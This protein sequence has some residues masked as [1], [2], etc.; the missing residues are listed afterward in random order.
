MGLSSLQAVQTWN[1]NPISNNSYSQKPFK[2]SFRPVATIT[3]A[4]ANHASD[5][6]DTNADKHDA[7]AARLTTVVEGPTKSAS[8]TKEQS[9]HKRERKD[10]TK[11]KGKDHR[12]RTYNHKYKNKVSSFDWA[13]VQ[14][15]QKVEGA[16]GFDKCFW[17]SVSDPE[18]VG[19]LMASAKYH[20]DRMTKAYD[21]SV[22]VLNKKCNAK[23]LYLEKPLLVEVKSDFVQQL[24]S[25]KQNRHLEYVDNIA[26]RPEGKKSRVDH[27]VFK[28]ND[29][30]LVIQKV[31]VAPKPSLAFGYIA[32]KWDLL[33]VKD[34]PKFRSLLT[35]KGIDPKSLEPKL[36][37]ERRKIECVM[38]NSSTYWYDLQGLID[39]E[40]NYHHL[41]VDSQF[42]VD[43]GDPHEAQDDDEGVKIVD[44]KETY[45][46]RHELIGK[47]NEMIQ[48][49]VNPPPEGVDE[50][51]AW[52]D[53]S[54]K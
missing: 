48:R 32:R 20:Y 26:P 41:D 34:L 28:E 11:P 1:E 13:D 46:M 33:V 35:S 24:N 7:V 18:N 27:K 37:D 40:G 25:L 52:D 6:N 30:Y 45:E 17:R 43:V 3:R 5:N 4:K 21:F 22:D 23:H 9:K 15:S 51:P 42:W 50:L 36:E 49:L 53:D 8:A 54:S 38:D 16:C 29:P 12:K 19:Y 44:L 2:S 39:A 10:K 14:V 31:K 47:F